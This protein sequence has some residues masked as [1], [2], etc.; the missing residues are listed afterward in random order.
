M[1]QKAAWR[2]PD[3][4]A[5]IRSRFWRPG[6]VELHSIDLTRKR[7]YSG[8]DAKTV[9]ARNLHGG[10][11]IKYASGMFGAA[12]GD[13]SQIDAEVRDVACPA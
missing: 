2:S 13:G 11:L 12:E 5:H 3:L 4:L 10:K 9:G 8:A 1:P 7:A 6:I